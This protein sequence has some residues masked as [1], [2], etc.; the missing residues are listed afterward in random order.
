MPFISTSATSIP[1][2]TNLKIGYRVY[3]STSAY[4]YVS[5]YPSYDEL[6]YT[7]YVPST[8]DWEIEY[9]VICSSCNGNK[10]SDPETTI[11][12]V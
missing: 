2:G 12:T 6:P 1:F 8:G 7:F 9:T 10:Y 11:V 4:T 3:G 5:E